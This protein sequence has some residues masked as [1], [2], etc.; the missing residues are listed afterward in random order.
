MTAKWLKVTEEI[1]LAADQQHPADAVMRDVLRPQRRLTPEQKRLISS[2]VFAYFRWFGWLDGRKPFVEQIEYAQELDERF[3]DNPAS[4]SDSDLI[5]RAVPQW[6]PKF[7]E[8]TAA[9]VRSLQSR[10]KIFLRARAGE[11]KA[12][13]EKL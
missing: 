2:A 1:I 13:A 9:W 7:L 3:N 10:P 11:G 5:S 12:L 8:V 6:I 4:F